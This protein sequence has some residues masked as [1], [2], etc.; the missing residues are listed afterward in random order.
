MNS[1]NSN[2][3]P[4]EL[5]TTADCQKIDQQAIKYNRTSGYQLMLGAGE[6]VFECINRLIFNDKNQSRT[7]RILCGVGNNGGDGYVV[8]AL[9]KKANF[10]VCVYALDLPNTSAAKDARQ[11]AQDAGTKIIDCRHA[12]DLSTDLQDAHVLVD[13][14]LGTGVNRPVQG[15]L[16]KVIC[17]MNES[18]TQIIACDVPSGLNSDTGVVKGCAVKATLTATFIALKQGLYTAQGKAYCGRQLFNNLNVGQ[19]AYQGITPSAHLLEVQ[20]LKAMIKPRFESAHKGVTGFLA[21]IGGAHGMMGAI[22]MTGK[23]AYKIGCGRVRVMTTSTHASLIPLYCPELLT[24]GISESPNAYQAGDLLLAPHKYTAV[25]IGPGLGQTK[26]S[27]RLFQEAMQSTLPM[28]IDADGLTLLANN[29]IYHN[30]WVLTPHPGEAATLL[31][32]STSEV[33]ANRFAAAKKI[34]Q[35]Y[36]GVCVLKGSGTLI[37]CSNELISVC[38]SGNAGQAVAGMGDVLTGFIAG[39]LAQGYACFNAAA[40]AVWIHGNAADCLAKQN[41]KIGMM[42]TDLFDYAQK[43]HNELVD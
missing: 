41:G 43:I 5:Y 26:W 16:K 7:I 10:N 23:A 11:F 31:N 17:W 34:T 20:A 28:V 21:T 2:C 32:C 1:L 40:L 9:A 39:L 27:A 3:L 4:G 33:Q 15:Y 36:G 25:A 22:L 8:A 38:P 13:A 6:F 18:S 14:L 29:P 37:C 19:K 12:P 30:N 42:A 35:K 24:E